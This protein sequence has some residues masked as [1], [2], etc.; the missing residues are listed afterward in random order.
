MHLL[1]CEKR[2]QHWFLHGLDTQ[3]TAPA[4]RQT[5]EGDDL[6]R[7]ETNRGFAVPKPLVPAILYPQRKGHYND[8]YPLSF[9]ESAKLCYRLHSAL[10]L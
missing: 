1:L 6:R 2:G 10:Y 9:I 5:R 8:N 4:G 3:R 7:D